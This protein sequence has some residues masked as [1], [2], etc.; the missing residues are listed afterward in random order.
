MKN[1]LTVLMIIIFALSCSAAGK[2]GDLTFEVSNP[3]LTRN[4]TLVR[5]NLFVPQAE[6]KREV[7]TVIDAQGTKIV[8]QLT[9]PGL[10]VSDQKP[11]KVGSVLRE[12]YFVAPVLKGNSSNKFTLSF[13]ASAKKSENFTWHKD[14]A[15]RHID[16]KKGDRQVMRYMC[17]KFDK[18]TKANQ[19]RTY[20][21][22]HQVY[23]PTGQ[24]LLTKGTGGKF[25]HHRG[26]YFGYSKVS[27]DKKSA[28]V[29]HCH[30]GESQ[31]HEEVLSKEAGPVMARQTLKINW[32]GQ[33][34]DN[35]ANETR[36][37]T[38]IPM[39][40]GLMVEF[41]S[42]LSTTLKLVNLNGDPQHAGCQFRANNL[43]ASKT[44][45]QTFYIRPDGKD[46]PGSYRNNH[47]NLK[48]NAMC[49]VIQDQRYTICYLD[50]PSNP[51]DA[52]Y[53]ERN[54]G[55]FGSYFKSQ[56]SPGKPLKINYRFFIKKGEMKLQEIKALHQEFVQT[57]K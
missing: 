23:D 39:N 26:I 42:E 53:S 33:K 52:L 56:I 5:K 43:V 20:K 24:Y 35:F 8:A 49:V 12:I 57:I 28:D 34:G 22:Y 3:S 46:K 55:R 11:S 15:G 6:A 21:V 4:Q 19:D 9:K 14:K 48:W 41:A 16:L 25:P 47:K 37:I 27:Y 36:E 18:S 38:A 32:N 2:S 1:A 13:S 29:W 31:T 10:S 50:H 30:K 40:G 7:V 17:E 54:Y 44:A 51:K 45:K